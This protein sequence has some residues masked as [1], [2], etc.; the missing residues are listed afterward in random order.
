MPSLEKNA[1]SEATVR[2]A[3]RKAISSYACS[4][5]SRNAWI[6]SSRNL[7]YRSHIAVT[8]SAILSKIGKMAVD[9]P[10]PRGTFKVELGPDEHEVSVIF[11]PTQ[12]TIVFF[13]TRPGELA[14][15]YQVHHTR[16]GASVALMKRK[17]WKLQESWHCRLPKKPGR[18]RKIPDECG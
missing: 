15:E 4:W 16:P 13:I 17:L 10:F 2:I 8:S 5:T 7:R 1:L 6:T 11:K 14:P 3:K 9:Q 12:S 18:D